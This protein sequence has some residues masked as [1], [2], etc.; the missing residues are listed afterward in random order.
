[1]PTIERQVRKRHKEEIRHRA[2]YWRELLTDAQFKRNIA[3]ENVAEC[4]AALQRALREAYT[5]GMT[6][7]EIWE[8]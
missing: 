4:L 2:A 3:D 8:N 7:K 5:L 6:T 1:M